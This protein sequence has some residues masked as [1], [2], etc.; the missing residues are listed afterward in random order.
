MS[1]LELT[2]RRLIPMSTV[3]VYLPSHLVVHYQ[4]YMVI[5]H[6]LGI[7]NLQVLVGVLI[8]YYTA[9][10]LRST[11]YN[12][13]VSKKL[14]SIQQEKRK[15]QSQQIS[16]GETYVHTHPVSNNEFDLINMS[17]AD[18]VNATQNKKLSIGNVVSYSI[19][20]AILAQQNTNCCSEILF[21]Q[22]VLQA[23]T[24]TQHQ[25]TQSPAKL[26]K[27]KLLGVPISLKDSVGVLGYDSSLGLT[28]YCNTP[29]SENAL[30]YDILVQQGAL[31]TTKTNIPQT[32]LSFECLNPIFGRTTNAYNSCYTSG[33]S[34]GGEASMLAYRASKVGIGTDIGGSVR[35]PAHFSGNYALKPTSRRLSLK[36]FRPS[37]PGQE[38]I[39]GVAGVM[40]NQVN[41]IVLVLK[42]LFSKT[43][44]DADENLIPLEFDEAE[45]NNINTKLV[46]GYYLND[47]VCDASPACKRAVIETVRALQA[48]GHTC[49]EFIPP[50]MVDAAV[51]YYSLMTSDN[52]E[53]LT[54]QLDG[55]QYTDYAATLTHTVRQPR[56]L[57]QLLSFISGNL[58][59]DKVASRLITATGKRSVSDAWKLQYK[60]RAYR[61]AF[62][63]AWQSNGNK[64]D[65]V[66]SPAHALPATPHDS[67]KNISYT[68]SYT[69][70]YNLL[71]LPAG[72]C[73]I[74]TVDQHKDQWNNKPAGVLEKRARAYYDPAKQHGLPV[75]VQ[76]AGLSMEDET[77]LRAMRI[78]SE[79]IPFNHIPIKAQ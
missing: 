21:E 62:F 11:L 58:L 18:I 54:Q 28:R 48:S 33:G 73:P 12:L 55:E 29:S 34:S 51:L 5:K 71:D 70:L 78:I 64:F 56:I 38:A 72:V 76:I 36:G 57:K 35:I 23:N 37:I 24:L 19:N 3:R 67:F 27:Y 42:E 16:F 1:Q 43:A 77:V 17:A 46:V 8:I 6:A 63:D 30:I 26:K 49:I 59:G 61:Q 52:S 2:L 50:N 45:C 7:T 74:T 15:L 32:L 79:L 69:F 44:W 53:S 22:V 39:P 31:C 13:S 60:R 14:K 66:L 4:R 40:A 65:V 75:G 68:C 10:K 25:A 47:G 9:S 41:D 20:Q